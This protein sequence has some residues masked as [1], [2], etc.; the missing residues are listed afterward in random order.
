MANQ[1]AVNPVVAPPS[2]AFQRDQTEVRTKT[3][4]R[5]LLDTLVTEYLALLRRYNADINRLATEK[6]GLNADK[7]TLTQELGACRE[8]KERAQTSVAQ[9]QVI[10][11]ELSSQLSSMVETTTVKL[12]TLNLNAES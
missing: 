1:P 4:S 11:T 3:H 9:M 8:D 2:P 10:I 6:A 12:N 5:A 7:A